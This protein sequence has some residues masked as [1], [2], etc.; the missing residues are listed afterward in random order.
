MEEIHQALDS[1]FISGVTTNPSLLARCLAQRPEEISLEAYIKEICTLR[2]K[3]SF[4]NFDQN[5]S[6]DSYPDF[7]ISVEVTAEDCHTMVKQGILFASW[8]EKVVVKVPL[9]PDGLQACRHLKAKGIR[10][11]VTLCFSIS[12]ALLAALAGADYVSVFLGRLDDRDGP[13]SGAK[14]LGMCQALKYDPKFVA[15][16]KKIQIIAAS[17][18]HKD[19]VAQ[20]IGSFTDIATLPWSV[21]QDLFKDSLTDKGL[22]IFKKDSLSWR[23]TLPE[24]YSA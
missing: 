1:G 2:P 19:H 9:T 4:Q 24:G 21:F 12:Q 22:D 17:V 15:D 13:E 20:S 7:C 14:L 16:K 6:Q 3:S 18:R 23:H 11:N 10:V 8:S 5:S